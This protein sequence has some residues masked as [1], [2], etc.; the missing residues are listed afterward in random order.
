MLEQRLSEIL[1]AN[2]LRQKLIT[3]PFFDRIGSADLSRGQ[4]GTF[5]GQWWHP[6][7]YFPVFLSRLISVAPPIDVK[8]AIGKILYQEL[9]E[10][11]PRRAHE[12]VYVDT[13]RPLG[14]ALSEISGAA[15]LPA[16]AR[17]V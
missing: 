3:H 16:T 5:L 15:P 17:L 8:T 2:A 9:G 7:H 1:K 11:D 12:V 10:G 14:F 6:L 13:M 4:V